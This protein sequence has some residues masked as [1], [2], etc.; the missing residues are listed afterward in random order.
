MPAIPE[1]PERFGDDLIE[2]REI[3]EWD[4][5]EVLIAF[6][7]DRDLHERI[8]M[9]KPPTAAQLGRE[10]EQ[11]QQERL[12]GRALKLTIVE[13]G[14]NDCC[15][16]VDID[17]FDWDTG[18]AAMRVWG[19]PQVRGRGYEQR[20]AELASRWL[21]DNVTLEELLIEVDG[22]GSQTVRREDLQ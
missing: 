14:R 22:A 17:R 18:S 5:P 15:G 16:R 21:F 7:D 1:P 9:A 4:I 10:V 2:L 19:A 8:G 12:A 11:E 6:Q 3:A 13:P 20:A